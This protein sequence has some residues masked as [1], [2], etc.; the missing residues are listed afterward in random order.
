LL[1]PRQVQRRS[2]V[3]VLERRHVLDRRDHRVARVVGE[4]VQKHDR[5]LGPP[6][7]ERGIRVV[8]VLDHAAEKASRPLFAADVL[9]APRR[10]QPLQ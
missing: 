10:P 5:A 8:R 4:L 9:H 7:D 1:R 6:D 2:V 3:E